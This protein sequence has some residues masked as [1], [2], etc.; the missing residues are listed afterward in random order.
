MYLVLKSTRALRPLPH[1]RAPPCRFTAVKHPTA[2]GLRHGSRH[3]TDMAET[4]HRYASFYRG[5]SRRLGSGAAKW[6]QPVPVDRADRIEVGPSSPTPAS[7]GGEAPAVVWS[8]G[9]SGWPLTPYAWHPLVRDPLQSREPDASRFTAVN[10]GGVRRPDGVV[11][12]VQSVRRLGPDETLR[13]SP[14]LEPET[15]TP[16]YRG[17][18]APGRGVE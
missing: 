6:R 11:S 9:A 18:T 10:R 7:S 16:L 3:R 15:C 12:R 14:D 5:K 17:K 13:M 8:T 1:Y 4:P 2:G